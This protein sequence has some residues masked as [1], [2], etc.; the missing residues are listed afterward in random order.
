MKLSNNGIV[1]AKIDK[2]V[3]RAVR[4][5]NGYVMAASTLVWSQTAKKWIRAEHTPDA[6]PLRPPPKPFITLLV[7]N[8]VIEGEN[9]TLVR[10][11]IEIFSQEIQAGYDNLMKKLPL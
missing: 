5:T 11:Y 9:G 10:D 2:K 3:T 8:S 7:S 1:V 6:T 4:L